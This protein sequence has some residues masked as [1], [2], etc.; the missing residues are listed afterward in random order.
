MTQLCA[1]MLAGKDGDMRINLPP[2]AI[3]KVSP[4]AKVHTPVDLRV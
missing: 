3:F 4:R 1:A 2:P